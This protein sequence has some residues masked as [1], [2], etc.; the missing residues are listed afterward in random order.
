[1]DVQTD[2]KYVGRLTPERKQQKN[3]TEKL[4]DMFKEDWNLSQVYKRALRLEAENRGIPAVTL[5]LA[6][7]TMSEEDEGNTTS[8]LNRSQISI[9]D[10][11]K[12]DGSAES[13]VRKDMVNA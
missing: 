10:Q 2:P 1:M 12:R 3:Q 11:Q 5:N 4:K 13:A 9:K 6:D 7:D 8:V